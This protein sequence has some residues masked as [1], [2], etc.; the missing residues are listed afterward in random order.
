MHNRR[1]IK[2]INTIT[3][4]CDVMYKHPIFINGKREWLEEIESNYSIGK[5]NTLIKN[6]NITYYSLQ[7]LN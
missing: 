5:L 4:L 7:L 1:G 6:K 2:T 3:I